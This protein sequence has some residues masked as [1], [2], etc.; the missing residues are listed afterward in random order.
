M[1]KNDG[2]ILASHFLSAALGFGT[3]GDS[4]ASDTNKP[5]DFFI[6]V[7]QQGAAVINKNASK[8]NLLIWDKCC[9]F[10]FFV[11]LKKK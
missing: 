6:T 2:D 1:G 7:A 8:P 10:F 5:A 4:F 11:I 3:G 9:F